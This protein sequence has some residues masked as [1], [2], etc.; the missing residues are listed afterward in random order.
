M[1]AIRVL[2]A[3]DHVVVRQGLA[4]VLTAGGCEVVGEA[5]DGLQALELA[6]KLSP[7]VA[8]LDLAM[9][10]LNGLEAARR[11]REELPRVRILVLTAH[12]EEEFVLPLVRAGAHGFLRKD[13]AAAELLA[14]V[15]ALAAGKGYFT[16]QVASIL[17]EHLRSGETAEDPLDRLTA[18]EREVFQLAAEGKT[19]KQVAALLGI[20]PKTAENHRTRILEKLGLHGTAELV[21][22]AAR[23]GWVR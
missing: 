18:R 11:I 10:R 14:A 19:T 3:D 17:A 7:A 16:P 5:G 21:R 15:R 1:T 6:R 20:S 8:I 4:G 23:R 2:L 13:C 12:D 9:P 22:Y